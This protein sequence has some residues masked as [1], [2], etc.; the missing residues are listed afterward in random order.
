MDDHLGRVKVLLPKGDLVDAIKRDIDG[1]LKV[2]APTAS[3]KIISDIQH[4]ILDEHATPL[5]FGITGR[6]LA[7]AVVND[8]LDVGDQSADLNG[9]IRKLQKPKY[10]VPEWAKEYLHVLRTIGNEF[11]HGQATAHRAS[12][13]LGPSDLEIQLLCIRRVLRF[14]IDA[15][16]ERV[17][18][19]S[20]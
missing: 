20:R 13:S 7:D 9:K 5:S 17:D 16:H 14:W 15:R 8:L 6:D 3:A 12:N 4:L 18:E 2:L 11:A 1:L 19:A 10:D